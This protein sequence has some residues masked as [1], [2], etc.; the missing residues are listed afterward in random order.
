MVVTAPAAEDRF[1]AVDGRHGKSSLPTVLGRQ[2]GS[3]LQAEPMDTLCSFYLFILSAGCRPGPPW[4]IVRAGRQGQRD[5][6]E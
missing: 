3:G 4:P 1:A 2:A 6:T 5:W